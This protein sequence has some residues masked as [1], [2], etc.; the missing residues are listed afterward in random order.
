[1]SS[2]LSTQTINGMEYLLAWTPESTPMLVNIP[3]PKWMFWVENMDLSAVTQFPTKDS[4]E[5]MFVLD[6]S[7]L[8]MSTGF[9]TRSTP[10]SDTCRPMLRT[11]G[12][13]ALGDS[14]L[15]CQA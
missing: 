2:E 5:Y 8:V 11:Q 14:A 1:M 6:T 4:G 15:C 7:P 3:K 10:G 12:S 13:M 9:K